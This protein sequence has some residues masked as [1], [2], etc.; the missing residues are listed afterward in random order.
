MKRTFPTTLAAVVVIGAVGFFIGRISSSSDSAAADS[1]ADALP[2]PTRASASGAAGGGSSASRAARADDRRNAPAKVRGQEALDRLEAIVRGENSLDRGR[3]MLAFI[4][5]LEP[6]EFEDAVAHFRSLGLTEDR[7]GEYG[8]LLSAWAQA[9]PVQALDYVQKNTNSGFALT[10]VLASWA[11]SDPDAAIA[12]AKTAHTGEGANPY[13][14]GIIRA[15]AATDTARATELLASMPRSQERGAG[16]DALVPQLLRLGPDAARKWVA[17]LKDEALRNGAMSRMAEQL[18][19]TDPKGTANWLLANPGE[20]LNNS[21]GRVV[22]TWAATDE[23]A[24]VI[25]FTGLPK[26]DAR[27]NAFRGIISAVASTNP[28]T[29]AAMIDRYSADVDDGTIRSFI[30]RSFGSDPALAINYAGR[31]ADPETR[32]RTYRR[33]LEFWLD[34]DPATAQAWINTNPLPANLQQHFQQKAAAR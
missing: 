33:T 16:L 10:T 26:G 25:F 11:G 1:A 31:I 15:L 32:D 24:A 4:D 8:M 13:L 20:A 19:K 30:W 14:P 28:Q 3:A 5:Q 7:F 34:R 27:N 21:L 6:G 2:P 9:D 23:K 17:A 18:A 12:W 29:A 22:G